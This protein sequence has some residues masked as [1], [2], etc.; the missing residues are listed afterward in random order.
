MKI[1]KSLKNYPI[2]KNITLLDKKRLL[3]QI[4]C[5]KLGVK[6]KAKRVLNQKY[7]RKLP[8][9][10]LKWPLRVKL[11]F[12]QKIYIYIWFLDLKPTLKR[13]HLLFWYYFWGNLIIYLFSTLGPKITHFPTIQD[14]ILPIYNRYK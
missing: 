11:T 5:Q 8:L 2:T 7:S 14:V 10:T 12:D 3:I 9:M 13:Y 4:L 6:K 1:H